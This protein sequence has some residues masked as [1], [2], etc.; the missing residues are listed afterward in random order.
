VVIRF[1][2]LDRATQQTCWDV[3]HS[4]SVCPSLSLS[5]SRI[6]RMRSRWNAGWR[7]RR[8]RF[9]SIHRLGLMLCVC[10]NMSVCLSVCRVYAG[11]GQSE[12]ESVWLFLYVWT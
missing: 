8:F 11:I 2:D 12:N 6:H 5:L 10:K 4:R 1:S 9:V 7:G 3:Y